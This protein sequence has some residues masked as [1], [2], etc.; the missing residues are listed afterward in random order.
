MR[1]KL[2]VLGCVFVGCH[3]N[4]DA[5]KPHDASV[6]A[7]D[8]AG[9]GRVEESA[10]DNAATGSVDTVNSTRADATLDEI[11]SGVDVAP[12][13]ADDTVT[14]VVAPAGTHDSTTPDSEDRTSGVTSSGESISEGDEA[15]GGSTSSATSDDATVNVDADDAASNQTD[16]PASNDATNDEVSESDANS[17]ADETNDETNPDD[18]NDTGHATTDV[19]SSE[20]EDDESNTSGVTSD[21]S[22]SPDAG[23]TDDESDDPDPSLVAPPIRASALGDMLEDS[24]LLPLPSTLDDADEIA[25]VPL[26]HS[27]EDSLGD[28]ASCHV[29]DY[30]LWTP[31]KI[32]RG[33]HVGGR[34]DEA[35]VQRRRFVVL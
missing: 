4:V 13:V 3:G 20:P 15:S 16:E 5:G 6:S 26:M 24:D 33:T 12:D 2:T 11:A 10:R 35:S 29:E 22:G 18:T 23:S 9:R 19:P 30:A 28:C 31:Q 34:H 21:P 1:A 17:N 32:R 7:Q 27:F 8:D 25:H 14:D